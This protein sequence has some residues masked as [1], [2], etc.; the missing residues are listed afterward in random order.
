M[1][2][3]AEGRVERLA[4][5]W[6]TR[7]YLF[8]WR[9]GERLRTPDGTLYEIVAVPAADHDRVV[10]RMLVLDAMKTPLPGLRGRPFV[11]RAGRDGVRVSQGKWAMRM[12]Q[13]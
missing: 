6:P 7:S 11:A 12:A 4:E 5:G 8:D 1:A 13:R 3:A 2:A 9:V 10:I